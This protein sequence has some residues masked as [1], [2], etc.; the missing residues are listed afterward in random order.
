MKS[1]YYNKSHYEYRKAVRTWINKEIRPNLESWS[2]S[3]KLPYKKIFKKMSEAGILASLMTPY[4]SEYTNVKLPGNLD[5]KKFDLFHEMILHEEL[6]VPGYPFIVSALVTGQVIGL[7]PV[8][9][10]AKPALKKKVMSEV[11]SGEKTICLAI[12]EP[13]AGSDVSGIRCKAVKSPCG[14]FYTV[15]GLKKWITT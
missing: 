11:L 9:F 15:T 7:S 10:F 5:P 8:K 1:L 14:K 3:G 13:Y 12:S 2:M 6:V 4:P